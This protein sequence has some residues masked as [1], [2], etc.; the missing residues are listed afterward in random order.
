MP[1]S[2]RSFIAGLSAAIAPQQLGVQRGI[3][4]REH[5]AA[6]VAAAAL[7]V[8]DDA[9]GVLDQRNQRLD[10]VRLQAGFDDDVDEAHRDLRVAVAIAAVADEPRTVGG[11]RVG[12]HLPIR[13]EVTRIRRRDDG[14]LD[15]RAPPC[16][17]RALLA[18]R[19]ATC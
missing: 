13:L 9:A 6:F 14:I 19:G 3:A 4:A 16:A 8:R 17:Q 7:P 10:V 12:V 2:I 11:R 5:V 1:P 15:S 18:R